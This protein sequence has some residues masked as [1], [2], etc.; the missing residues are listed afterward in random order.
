MKKRVLTLA[1][2]Y[3]LH[4]STIWSAI[5]KKKLDVSKNEDGHWIIEEDS[6][7]FQAW[8]KKFAKGRV[9]QADFL[10][11]LTDTEEIAYELLANPALTQAGIAHQMNISVH[12]VYFH[13]KNIYAK[14][15]VRGRIGLQRVWLEREKES[16]LQEKS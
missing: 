3:D 8:V 11:Q 5:R 7:E 12:T 15:G 10:E 4:P 16:G 14:M 13:A 9:E 2:I 6:P 1:Y